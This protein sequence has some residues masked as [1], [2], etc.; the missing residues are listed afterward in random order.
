M[1]IKRP[2][3]WRCYEFV[4]SL[5]VIV[6]DGAADH[7]CEFMVDYTGYTLSQH[8]GSSYERFAFYVID[9]FDT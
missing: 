5:Y 4:H 9:H 3:G 1:R 2:L 8:S 7:M 6:T